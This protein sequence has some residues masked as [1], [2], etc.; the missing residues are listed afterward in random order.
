LI[1][2][3]ANLAAAAALLLAGRRR[4]WLFVAITGFFVGAE[5]AGDLFANQSQ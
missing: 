5:V 4:L 1:F 2:R 3:I